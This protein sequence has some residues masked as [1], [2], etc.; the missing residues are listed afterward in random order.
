MIL[1]GFNFPRFI[2]ESHEYVLISLFVRLGLLEKYDVGF[3]DDLGRDDFNA[4]FQAMAGV[5]ITKH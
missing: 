4:E 2:E 1:S 3:L 5:C